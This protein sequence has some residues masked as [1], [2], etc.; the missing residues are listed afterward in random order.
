M[1]KFK[2]KTGN[3]AYEVCLYERIL[4]GWG[5]VCD[6]C[7]DSLEDKA[8]YLPVANRVFCKRC[9]DGEINNLPSYEED[10][11][12]EQEKC[13]KLEG[14]IKDLLEGELV[15]FEGYNTAMQDDDY[16][17]TIY[18]PVDVPM[19]KAI[20]K[21][22]ANA[23]MYETYSVERSLSRAVYLKQKGKAVMQVDK[24]FEDWLKE[25]VKH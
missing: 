6:N 1:K 8:Y 10:K 25:N 12:Y 5:D 23:M 14:Y 9:F 21:Y 2:T 20:A 11:E 4:L 17:L 13:E 3:I 19:T 18:C 24:G 7:N 16:V 15:P 22:F